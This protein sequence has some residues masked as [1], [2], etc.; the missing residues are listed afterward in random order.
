MTSPLKSYSSILRRLAPKKKAIRHVQSA[1]E[2]LAFTN[3]SSRAT[4]WD[5]PILSAVLS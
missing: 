3:S 1:I 2:D 4:I 5:V